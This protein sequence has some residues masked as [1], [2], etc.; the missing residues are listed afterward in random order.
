MRQ[1]RW[2]LVKEGA[3]ISEEGAGAAGD[4]ATRLCPMTAIV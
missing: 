4:G 1:S 3:G 2:M